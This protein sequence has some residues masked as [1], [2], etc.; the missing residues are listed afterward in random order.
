MDDETL[1]NEIQ[2][3]Q[4]MVATMAANMVQSN[5]GADPPPNLENVII[6]DLSEMEV[7]MASKYKERVKIGDN[8]NGTPIFAWAVG[9]TKEE[10]HRSIAS[11]LS[12]T[13]AV[14][15]KSTTKI[16]PEWESY[17]QIWFDTFHSPN[18]APKT[19]VKDSSLFRRHIKP[20]FAG[21]RMDEITTVDV[22]SFLQ[23]KVS[24]CRSQVRD[25][26]WMT[27][28][29]LS[30]AVEDGFISKNPMDSDR[31]TNP[32][33]KE[34]NERKALTSEEQADIIA[35]LSNIQDPYGRLFMA[36]LMFTCMR[37]CEILGL[38]WS[39]I[40]FERRMIGINRDLVFVNGMPTVG[41]TKTEDSQREIP[42]DPRLYGHL[43][44]MCA[45]NKGIATGYVFGKDGKCIS[46]ESV[47][48]RMW[49]GI[50]SDIDIHS[51][52]PYVGR[53][54]FATNMSRAGIPIRT[55][56][57]MMGHKDERMLL[58]TYQHIDKDDLLK[59]N[60]SMNAYISA[61]QSNC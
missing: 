59:A 42:I 7:E 4:K 15:D 54:T 5:T 52:T 61:L 29:I 60:E 57:A 32:S 56:M 20:A 33:Q 11:L 35:H 10:L 47:F 18:I 22:Q 53:H 49:K 58:R 21:K 1:L 39:D 2:E 37:P 3:L 36:F 46:S 14:S 26:M 17:A 13:H 19:L 45:V 48:R 51:M 31:I 55:A 9:D 25:I 23:T 6:S 43:K 44:A 12:Q 24:Y 8:G 50:K 30:S 40:D 34:I 41:D 27:K 38:Q 16:A 28:K